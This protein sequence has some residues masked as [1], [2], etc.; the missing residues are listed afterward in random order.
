M[1]KMS[2]SVFLGICFLFGRLILALDFSPLQKI[3][4]KTVFEIP[5]ESPTYLVHCGG[6]LWTFSVKEQALIAVNAVLPPQVEKYP[7]HIVP[8]DKTVPIDVAAMTCQQSRLLVLV[9]PQ[10]KAKAPAFKAEIYEFDIKNS[11]LEKMPLHRYVFPYPGRVT[12]LFCNLEKCW[13]L[14]KKLF[15]T[16]NFKKWLETSLPP[17]QGVPFVNSRRHENPFEDWQ[18]TLVLAPGGYLKGAVNSVGDVAL[19]DPF[20]SQVVV[21]R[22]PDWEK[23]GDFGAWEGRF[24]SPKA[25][26]FFGDKAVLISDVKLKAIFIFRYDGKYLG[27]ISLGEDS[28]FSPSYALGV[29]TLG[30]RVYISDFQKNRLSAVEIVDLGAHLEKGSDLEIRQNLLRRHDFPREAPS[31]LCLTCHDGSHSNQLFKFVKTPFHHPLQCSKCHSPHHTEKNPFFLKAS[32]QKLC[33]SCHKDHAKPE[34][35]HIWQGQ[36]K[37]GSCIDCHISHA[38]NDKLLVKGPPQ[39]CMDCHREQSVSHRS[40]NPIINV[41]QG[42]RLKFQEGKMSCVTCHE[43]HKTDKKTS[44]LRTPDEVQVFC[45]SCHGVKTK[46]LYQDF[47]KLMKGK[48]H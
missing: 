6:A 24:L 21:R 27:L 22:G 18:S 36:K 29:T 35:N 10:S 7:L 45:A 4:A 30:N 47:H 15:S 9:N 19:L 8:S 34:N 40:M 41:D 44:F 11:R 17:I 46:R 39:L 48:G 31:T 43:T 16:E 38:E 14:Q 23:W 1:A 13:V 2:G 20:H 32:P 3:Q 25:I 26:G 12:D 28:V 33:L 5:I 37:G 42:S